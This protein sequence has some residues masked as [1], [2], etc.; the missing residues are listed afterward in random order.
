MDLLLENNIFAH[1]WL[2]PDFCFLLSI[3]AQFAGT[4]YINH[5]LIYLDKKLRT[6]FPQ[7]MINSNGYK[8]LVQPE[9]SFRRKG[10]KK[11]SF[12]FPSVTFQN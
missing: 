5:I 6:D 9:Y 11:K 1:I 10:H 2:Y 3:G 7:Y 12:I 8:K 4:V